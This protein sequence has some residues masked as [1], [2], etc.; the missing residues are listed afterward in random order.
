MAKRMDEGPVLIFSF[1]AQQTKCVRDPTGKIVEGAEDN[2][3]QS[4]YIFAMRRDTNIFDP[5]LAWQ[6]L[7]IGEQ[8]SQPI[9]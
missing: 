8:H 5:L 9:I 7:E 2:I 6:V 4:I 3:V 1:H